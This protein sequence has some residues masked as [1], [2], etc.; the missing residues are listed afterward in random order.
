MSWTCLICRTD[1]TRGGL[2]EVIQMLRTCLNCK[3]D[4][5]MQGKWSGDGLHAFRIL[6]ERFG[7]DAV[8]AAWISGA[9]I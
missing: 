4:V 8:A 1:P 3:T 5:V 2:D 6:A 7:A 9:A